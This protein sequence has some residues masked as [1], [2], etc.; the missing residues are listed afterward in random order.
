MNSLKKYLVKQSV[1][2][3]SGKNYE[4]RFFLKLNE[5]EK[6]GMYQWQQVLVKKCFW[7]YFLTKIDEEF[8]DF[9][10]MFTQI[11]LTL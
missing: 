4:R 10:D 3:I 7:G 11:K 8:W 6:V 5:N 9:P 2:T 1:Y